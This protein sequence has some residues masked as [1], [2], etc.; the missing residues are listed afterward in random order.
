M[1]DFGLILIGAALADNF[2]LARMLGVEPWLD[3]PP[4]LA[5]VAAR[6][7]VAALTL[8]L[9]AAT[10][11]IVERALLQPLQAAFLRP[12]VL[13]LLAAGLALAVAYLLRRATPALAATAELRPA[14]LG[15]DGAVLAAAL[16]AATRPV[17]FVG[18]L[19][20][21]LGAGLGFGLVLLMF[22]AMRARLAATDVPA[23]FRGAP[24][25]LVTA[26]LLALAFLGFAGMGG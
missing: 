1:T 4:R 11:W 18:A 26:A 9:A 2:V 25:G 8:T 19:A 10:G 14:L 17:D 20:L 5:P 24:I 15:V 23:P 6:A 16:L 3:A 13:I 22:A 12:F 21:G 7:L